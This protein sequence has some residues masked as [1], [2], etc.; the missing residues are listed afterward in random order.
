MDTDTG[1]AR[2]GRWDWLPTA[3]P[4]VSR[5][6]AEKRRVL[7]DAH[8]NECWR[9][10]MAGEP[11]WFFA[12]EGA[13]AIGTPPTEPQLLAL[14]GWEVMPAQALVVMATPQGVTHGAH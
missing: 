11:G 13:I 9:R 1:R 4:G 2:K 6:I 12:R 3:M 14:C 10:G 5:L 8:V 7:G